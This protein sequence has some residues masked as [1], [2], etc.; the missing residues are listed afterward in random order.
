MA[1]NG[2][3]PEPDPVGDQSEQP[4][5]CR[6]V[7]WNV[8]RKDLTPL[9]CDLAIETAPDVVVLNECP[10]PIAETL[11]AL[12]SRGDTGFFVPKSASEDRFHCFC[13]SAA[14]DLSE[15]HK[16]IRTSYRRLTLDSEH[17]VFGL[18][19]G[20]DMR[21][22]DAA[23][24]QEFAHELAN[25]LAFVKSQCGHNRLILM[26]DFNMNPYDVGMNLASGL[27]AMMTKAC[28]SA[29][30]R[31]Y[32]EK[33]YDFYYNP[34]WSLFGD[35]SAGPAGTFYNLSGPGMYGWNMIDQVIMSHSLVHQLESVRIVSHAGGRP[36]IDD[37]GRPD[38]KH[39]SDHLPIVLELKG[40][41]HG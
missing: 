28:V 35:G 40:T 30:Q 1:K 34:M 24:R 19:H 8:N 5:P 3:W 16:G 22:Y 4:T 13:R 33:Q 38:S 15:L 23:K 39:A 9:V 27:N 18:V 31:T 37:R 29:G 10:V 41:N 17:A 12:R 36:L 20:L 32:L 11:Q 21:N 6:I 26:G 25:Q 2:C 7:F 14:L